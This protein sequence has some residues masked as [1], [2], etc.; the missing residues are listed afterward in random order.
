MTQ[1]QNIGEGAM[2]PT[3]SAFAPGTTAALTSFED[4]ADI[5]LVGRSAEGPVVSMFGG[6]FSRPR[7]LAAGENAAG[8]MI[9][10]RCGTEPKQAQFHFSAWSE[11][12]QTHAPGSGYFLRRRTNAKL[13]ERLHR[14]TTRES[15]I[16]SHG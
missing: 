10:R 2:F 15:F 11:T 1:S 6:A 7:M 16:H 3:C 8:N 13:S 9:L 12:V 5:L 4:A 14:E